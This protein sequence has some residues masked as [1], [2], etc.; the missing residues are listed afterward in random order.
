M[1]GNAKDF[2][3]LAGEDL[4]SLSDG[5]LLTV[6]A[7]GEQNTMTVSWGMTGFMWARS[8]F[9]VMVRRSRHTFSL[10]ERADS[11][12]VSIPKHPDAKEWLAYCGSKSGRD[13]DKF[14]ALG[15]ATQPAKVVNGVVIDC[16]GTHFEAR[17]L[18][19]VDMAQGTLDKGVQEA[20]Y[21]KD[22]LHVLYFGEILARYS[23]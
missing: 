2:L 4:V 22:G 19:R 20:H 10:I 9:M 17:I 11:F 12:T 14:A 7:G 21:V 23:K 15:L 16:P 1:A 5:A 3:S 18:H 6:A 13:G 8:V